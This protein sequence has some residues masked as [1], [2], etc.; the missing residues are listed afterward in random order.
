M[1]VLIVMKMNSVVL[2][3]VVVVLIAT[4]HSQ[5][6]WASASVFVCFLLVASSFVVTLL[7]PIYSSHRQRLSNAFLRMSTTIWPNTQG[8]TEK[9][10]WDRKEQEALSE[11]RREALRERATVCV[12]YVTVC[13]LLITAEHKR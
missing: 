8:Q 7:N 3:V 5:F 11:K 4:A 10:E 9:I 6:R 13:V 1:N 2:V 12:M